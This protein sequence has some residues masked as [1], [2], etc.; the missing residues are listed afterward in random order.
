MQKTRIHKTL[1]PGFL[2]LALCLIPFTAS[3]QE[4]EFTFDADTFAPKPLS[5][6]G[7]LE[8]WP[9]FSRLNANSPFYKIN[10]YDRTP[11][12]WLAEG[13]F[14]LLAGLGYRKGI[15]EAYLEPY[16]DTAVSPFE[17]VAEGRLFQGYLS[18]KPSPS[19]TIHAGKRTLRWGKGY[20]WSPAAVVERVKNPNEPD[21]ARE[22]YWMITADF[23]KSFGG[24]LQTL[25]ITPVLI[26]VSRSINRTFSP[27]DGLNFS[28]KVYLLLLDTDIDV[29]LSAG[30]P[31]GPRFGLDFSRNLRSNWEV[32]GEIAYL[33]NVERRLVGDDGE[34]REDTLSA[35]SW[36]LGL[37]YL[38]AA[39]TTTILEYHH[40]GTGLRPGDVEAF[41]TFV[42]E[43]YEDYLATGNDAGLIEASGLSS[44]AGFTPMT[45]YL[46]LRV[47]QK[48]PFGIL[49]LNP[50]ATAIVNLSDGSA[51]WSP[52]MTYKGITNLELRIKA[53]VLTGKSGDEFREK[54]NRFRLE[55]RARYYF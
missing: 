41:H 4:E 43:S 31:R 1:F 36:L 38:S 12:K 2:F 26:P 48:D 53:A 35:T 34:I 3:G 29:I 18:L 44:Y 8:M 32:H 17:S 42:D 21:L 47:I 23:T 51:S 55:L 52:E 9:S 16:L 27:T 24:A 25:S 39:E 49:Y 10:F 22:G 33:R 13:S 14:G 54:R 5:L 50:A 46:F 19:W 11:R 37:R 45:D 40:D 7:Y 20:A 15:F 6:D 30:E 28:G